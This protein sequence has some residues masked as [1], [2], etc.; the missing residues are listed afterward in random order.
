LPPP[1]PEKNR[2][3]APNAQNSKLLKIANLRS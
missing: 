2:Y 1:P 3:F